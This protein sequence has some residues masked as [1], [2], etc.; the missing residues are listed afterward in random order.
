MPKPSISVCNTVIKH[1][2]HLK[3]KG[4]RGKHELQTSVLHIILQCSQITRVFHHS[5]IHCLGFFIMLCFLHATN[6]NNN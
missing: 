4:R 2:W 3:A 6:R 5:V 1:D